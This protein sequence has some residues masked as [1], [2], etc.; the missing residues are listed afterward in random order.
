MLE[1]L[2]LESDRLILTLLTLEYAPVIFQEFTAEI[3]TYT[4]PRPAETIQQTE[5]FIRETI[6]QRLN[7]TNLTMAIAKKVSLEFVGVCALH[8]LHTDTPELGIWTKK[9]AHG[10]GFGREAIRCL[11][12]WADETLDYEYLL[13]PVDRRNLPSQKNCQEPKRTHHPGIS[14]DESIWQFIRSPGI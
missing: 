4:Y 3:T 2:R 8:N 5:R 9:S 12:Q 11:K 7:G 10:S 13:Y 1:D 6:Q 14:A